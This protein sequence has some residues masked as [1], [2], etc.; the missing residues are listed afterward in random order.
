MEQAKVSGVP[1]E[2]AALTGERTRVV[3]DPRLGGFRV[4]LSA[5]VARVS[6]GQGGWRAPDTSLTLGSDGLLHPV[7]A[8][9]PIAV[10]NGGVG[11]LVSL[12]V[13]G[14][15]V[16]LGLEGKLPAPSVV[17]DTAT[18]AE[19]LP[20]V[21]VVARA[22][23]ESVSTF[24]VVKTREAGKNPAVRQL[25]LALSGAGASAGA[26]RSASGS[27]VVVKNASGADGVR[28]SAAA[29]WDSTGTAAQTASKE[30][31][32]PSAQAKGQDRKSVV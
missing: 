31:T 13:A 8:R 7:A 6:D 4:E 17:G 1:V 27:D 22:S 11:D 30:R 5:A 2:V 19:V 25:K 15:K 20:G 26:A 18:F 24:V 12:T 21:D 10:S 23:V 29:M 9:L 32:E 14:S 28:L 16:G 3:A